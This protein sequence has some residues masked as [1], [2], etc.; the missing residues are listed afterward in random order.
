MQKCANLVELEKYCQTHIFLQNF[1]LM[2]PRTSLPKIYK[3]LL[4]TSS[5]CFANFANFAN[6]NR[7]LLRKPGLPAA[8]S[9]QRTRGTRRR[10]DACPSPRPPLQP[11][12]ALRAEEANELFILYIES[13]IQQHF[14]VFP[15]FFRFF[16]TAVN[17]FPPVIQ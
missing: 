1:A 13:E 6:P 3:I 11:A 9:W 5:N 12:R 14:Y 15:L 16:S 7:S 10:A 2:K 17:R 8:G 4:V